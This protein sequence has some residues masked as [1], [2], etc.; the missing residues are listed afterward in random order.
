MDCVYCKRGNEPNV[1][2][3][4]ECGAEL[5]P[6]VDIDALPYQTIHPGVANE[7]RNVKVGFFNKGDLKKIIAYI[8]AS[9]CQYAPA[10]VETHY[11]RDTTD[12]DDAL[13][14]SEIYFKLQTLE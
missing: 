11:K 10:R 4:T 13:P 12:P 3:C 1:Q 9:G 14:S 6:I 2:F 5:L 7:L 8:E